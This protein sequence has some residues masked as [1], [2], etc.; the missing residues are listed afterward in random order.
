MTNE[1]TFEKLP[2]AVGFLIQEV[3]ELKDFIKKHTAKQE[4]PKEDVWMSVTDLMEYLPDKPSRQ[5]VYHWVHKRE[6]PHYKGSKKI[7]FK[8]SEIDEWLATN[9]RKSTAEIEAKA[10][11]Y[12]SENRKAQRL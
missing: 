1:L 11:K 6:I 9:K 5:T 12:L 2:D 7:R 10:N 4:A 8:Q 3:A